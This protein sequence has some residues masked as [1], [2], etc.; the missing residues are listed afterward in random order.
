[1]LDYVLNRWPVTVPEIVQPFHTRQSEFVVEND[2][3]LWDIRVI[4]PSK[5]RESAGRAS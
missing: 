1:M 4:I 2:S 5:L 3:L